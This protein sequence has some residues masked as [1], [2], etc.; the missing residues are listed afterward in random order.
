M[1]SAPIG[2]ALWISGT[3]TVDAM[4]GTTST[5]PGSVRMS[6]MTNGLLRGDHAADQAL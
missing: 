1:L 3:A 2:L 5:Y 6:P 4:P